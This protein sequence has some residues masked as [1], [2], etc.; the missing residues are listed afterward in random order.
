MVGLASAVER[1]WVPR[2]GSDR[3]LRALLMPASAA[4]GAAV[5][6][7]NA[8][9]DA[10]W[11]AVTRVPA[12]VVSV[13]NLTVGGTGKTPAALW[14]ARELSR[15]GHR[16]A[17]VARGYRKR[18]RGVVVVGTEGVP[19]VSPEDGGD[20]AAMLARRFCGPVLTGER[21]ADAAAAAC[22]RFGADTLVLDDGFQHRALARDADLVLVADD[23]AARRLLPAGS[24]REPLRA[25]ARAR[26]ALVVGDGDPGWPPLPPDIACFRGRVRP[27]SL[28]RA[29][30]T[31][32]SEES[33]AALA[34]TPVVAVAGVARPE[35]FVRTLDQCGARVVRT[36]FFPDHHAYGEAEIAA[37]SD[38]ARA[39][40]LV[41]TE[42][43][44]VKL[45]GRAGMEGTRA[46]RVSLEVDDGGRLLDLLEEG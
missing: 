42:K 2:S 24:R 3:V 25:L 13:G 37:L 40:L 45:A 11:L 8:L 44:L 19:L 41:T 7:R 9:Y 17:L 26:A 38:A 6:L 43:D 20:E 36:I 18:R 12:R 32:W 46:V 4:Y 29:D 27:E 16:V 1:A 21:R 31:A 10:G 23:P 39:G 22:A 35:R 30:G 5:S 33:I 34:G 15:R 28:V 14:L